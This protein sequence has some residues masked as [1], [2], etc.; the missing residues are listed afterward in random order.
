MIE[1]RQVFSTV[2]Y[3]VLHLPAD[4]FGVLRPTPGA[5]QTVETPQEPAPIKFY[6]IRDFPSPP[7]GPAASLALAKSPSP[8]FYLWRRLP[9][10]PAPSP[11]ME[12]G[13]KLDAGENASISSRFN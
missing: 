11:R 12:I 4:I 7:S 8:F 6:L 5:L 1:Y 10:V 9:A 2:L 3:T 13:K